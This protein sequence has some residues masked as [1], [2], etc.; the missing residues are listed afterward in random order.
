M[1]VRTWQWVGVALFAV[2]VGVLLLGSQGVISLNWDFFEGFGWACGIWYL[3][4]GVALRLRH[5]H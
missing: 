2:L 1:T 4:V 3:G 5:S